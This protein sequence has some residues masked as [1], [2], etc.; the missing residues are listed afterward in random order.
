MERTDRKADSVTYFQN[1]IQPIW[2]SNKTNYIAFEIQ[3]VQ[4]VK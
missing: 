2:K 4:T 3:P 1:K